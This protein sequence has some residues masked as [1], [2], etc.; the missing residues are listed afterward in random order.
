MKLIRYFAGA[1]LLIG[2][3]VTAYAAGMFTNLPIV[4]GAAYCALFAGDGVTCAANVPAGPTALTG[5]ER[6]PAD[7]QLSGGASPQ[8]VLV[9]SS[10]FATGAMQVVTTNASVV[11]ANGISSLVSNQ[12]AATI[13]LITLPNAPMDNQ[14]LRIANAG[15]GILTLTSIAVAAGSGQ[16]IV[17]GAAPTALAIQTG[18]TSVLSTIAYQYKLSSKIWYR[19]E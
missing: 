8:T 6:I 17:Q 2:A 11:V 10:L 16:T 1:T 7:T 18:T 12:G 5:N 13:A 3:T 19:V 14:V 9:P 4:G 15:S